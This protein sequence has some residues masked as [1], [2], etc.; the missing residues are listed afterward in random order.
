MSASRSYSLSLPP[1]ALLAISPSQGEPAP[2]P[3]YGGYPF[4]LVVTFRR[5]KFEWRSKFNPGPLGP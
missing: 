1:L 3:N 2:A 4:G 5:A